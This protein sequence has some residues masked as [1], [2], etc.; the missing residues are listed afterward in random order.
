MARN[1]PVKNLEE[2]QKLDS[3][4]AQQLSKALASLHNIE[5]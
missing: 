3:T 4:V 5:D 1:T 2:N